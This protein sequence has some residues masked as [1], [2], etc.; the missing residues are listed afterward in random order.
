MANEIFGIS[1]LLHALYHSSVPF[2]C[3]SQ[4]KRRTKWRNKKAIK[5]Y[6]SNQAKQQTNAQQQG[7]SQISNKN[8]KNQTERYDKSDYQSYSR[9]NQSKTQMFRIT[10]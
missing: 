1:T 3:E 9:S 4:A 6:K 5:K 10:F 2:A 8:S 7:V